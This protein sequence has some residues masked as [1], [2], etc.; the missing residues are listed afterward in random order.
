MAN[1]ERA[2]QDSGGRRN[3]GVFVS[4]IVTTG[5]T[6]KAVTGPRSPTPA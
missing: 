3:S 6:R 1:F 4:G 2:M 5:T